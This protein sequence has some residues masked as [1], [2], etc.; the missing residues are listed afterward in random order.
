MKEIILKVLN[1]H[2]DSQGN[3]SSD[4]FRET[5]AVEIAAVLTSEASDTNSVDDWE[6]KDNPLNITMWKG[7]DGKEEPLSQEYLDHWKCDHCGDNTHEVDYDY[8]GNNRNHLKCEL[9]HE[10]DYNKY[11]DEGKQMELEFP[12]EK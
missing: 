2:S 7:W 5:L 4:A 10:N 9:E 1:R 6:A 12:K 11:L 3:M 8:L